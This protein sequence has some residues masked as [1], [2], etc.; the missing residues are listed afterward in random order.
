MA[1]YVGT[2]GSAFMDDRE[3]LARHLGRALLVARN[4]RKS[5]AAQQRQMEELHR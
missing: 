1:F 4:T 5:I 2:T 3:I